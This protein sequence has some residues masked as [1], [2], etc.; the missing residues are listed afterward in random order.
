MSSI[1]PPQVIVDYNHIKGHA[2]LVKHRP[3]YTISEGEIPVPRV[4]TTEDHF[5]KHA[6]CYHHGP[7][8]GPLKGDCEGRNIVEQAMIEV[9]KNDT[10]IGF[11]HNERENSV[12]LLRLSVWNGIEDESIGCESRPIPKGLKVK[13]S[14][15][16]WKWHSLYIKN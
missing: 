2:P 10:Y 6:R 13:S 5:T 15:S 3:R 1:T 11:S 7:G 16:K 14:S 4:L 12:Y 8:G 9:L